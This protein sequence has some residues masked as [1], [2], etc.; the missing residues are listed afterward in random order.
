MKHKLQRTLSVA[1]IFGVLACP[2]QAG[3]I[4]YTSGGVDLVYDD[5]RDLTWVADPNLFKTQYDADNTTVNQII[6]D[7]GTVTD[8]NGS[9]NLVA[10][11]FNTVTGGM[12]W[13]G[14]MAWAEWLGNVDYGGANDWGLWSA[15][16]S[17]STGPC[18]FFNCTDSDLGHLYYTEGGLAAGQSITTS[19]EL[20]NHFTNLQPF[21]H[22]SGTE[23]ASNPGR[24]W[25]FRTDNGNQGDGLGNKVNQFHGWAVRSGQV[26]AVP[27]PATGLLMA[28]G[29][30]GLIVGCRAKKGVRAEWH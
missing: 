22:W 4:S 17:D 23:L 20:N 13:W 8:G 12:T 3:L 30:V 14:A 21:E 16:N 24:A 15:L 1:I 19:T 25:S 29:L 6:S 28:L 7:I 18:F 10:G 26:A 2:A 5:D 11:D 27:L 9:H